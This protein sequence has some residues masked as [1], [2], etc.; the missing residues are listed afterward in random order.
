[1]TVGAPAGMPAAMSVPATPAWRLAD[2]VDAFRAATEMELALWVGRLE[3]IEHWDD[4]SEGGHADRF[5]R[6]AT[7]GERASALGDDPSLSSADRSLVEAIAFMVGAEQATSRWRPELMWVNPAVGLLPTLV[8]M[9]PRYGLLS[10]A[11]GDGYL[12]KIS[13]MPAFVDQWCDRLRRAAAVGRLPIGRLI[14]GSIAQI[15]DLLAA[16]LGGGPFGGQAPPRDLDEA[17]GVLWRTELRRRLDGEVTAALGRLRDVLGEIRPVAPA[18]DTPGLCHLAGGAELYERLVAANT[19]IE[20]SASE[21]HQIGHEQVA[22]VEHDFREMAGPLLGTT[23]IGEIFERLRTD[24]ALHYGDSAELVADATETL[25]RATAAAPAWFGRLPSAGCTA[26]AIDAGALAYYSPPARN[27]SRPGAFFF[28]TSDPTAWGR[29]DLQSTTFH[30]GIPGHHLQ[31]ALAQEID[32]LHPLLADEYV[33]AYCEGWGLY[34]ERLADEMGLYSTPLDRVGMLAGA[35]MRA[36][37]LV[38]DTGLHALGW[39]R[40]QAI[41]YMVEHSPMSR[42]QVEAEV[43]RYIGDPGQALGY[44]IG[45]LEIDRIR[46][47]AEQRLGARFDIRAFHDTVLTVGSVPLTTLARVVDEWVNGVPA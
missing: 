37:R 17:T 44:M 14:D 6:L 8:A 36:C 2:E 11:D 16:P 43:D 18:D 19:S 22:R 40:E 45:R 24:P 20:I 31:L 28:N 21:V 41:A 13:A 35:A 39:S 34:A 4:I 15:D 26:S 30:E 10:A 46:A 3:H 42:H 25:A 29:F 27:G 1:M 7:Y 9:L 12:A 33:V 32:G 47:D 23:D 5:A 38:V